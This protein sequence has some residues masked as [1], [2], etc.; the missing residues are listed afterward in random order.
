MKE[1]KT[2][3]VKD[4]IASYISKLD[5]HRQQD[6]WHLVDVYTKT[7]QE[8]PVMWGTSIIGFGEKTYKYDS[9]RVINYFYI[10]FSIRKKAITL[11]LMQLP[12]E[13]VLNR[14]G[15]LSHGVGCIYVK[16]LNDIDLNYL[17]NVIKSA[18]ELAKS[19]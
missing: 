13:K 15:K 8:L 11:Y 5:E 17:S 6:A 16:L 12:S 9:G 18:V 14:L 10:G 19:A 7:T 4:S 3:P 1:N 2:Q